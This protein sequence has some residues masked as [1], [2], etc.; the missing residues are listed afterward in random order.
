MH[1]LQQ[2]ELHRVVGASTGWPN[3]NHALWRGQV[4]TQGATSQQ[5]PSAEERDQWRRVVIRRVN[6]NAVEGG[7]EVENQRAC[8]LQRAVDAIITAWHVHR[9]A[10]L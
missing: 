3:A 6:T 2:R 7:A 9:L 4:G 1:A 8:N 5:S 10:I